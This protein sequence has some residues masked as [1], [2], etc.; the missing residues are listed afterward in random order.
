MAV[1]LA[2]SAAW[3]Q[4]VE[5]EVVAAVTLDP[6]LRAPAA[7]APLEAYVAQREAILAYSGD[8]ER[9][10]FGGDV[11]M[12][13]AAGVADFVVSRATAELEVFGAMTLH[14]ALCTQEDISMLLPTACSVL[15]SIVEEPNAGSGRARTDALVAAIRVDLERI[16][17]AIVRLVARRTSQLDDGVRLSLVVF[18]EIIDALRSGSDASQLTDRIFRRAL[19]C[20]VTG[21]GERVVRACASPGGRD[22]QR[23]LLLA[24]NLTVL[25][26]RSPLDAAKA[27]AFFGLDAASPHAAAVRELAAEVS[28]EA[29]LVSR[30]VRELADSE[31]TE[32]QRQE[33]SQALVRA[34]ATLVLDAEQAVRAATADALALPP[35]RT[36]T[37]LVDALFGTIRAAAEGE[38]TIGLAHIVQLLRAI[39]DFLAPHVREA[40][41]EGGLALPDEV[42]RPMTLVVALATAESPE[43]VRAILEQSAAPIGSWREKRRRPLVAISAFVGMAG[44]FDLLLTDPLRQ[45]F[46]VALHATVGLDLNFYGGLPGGTIGLYIHILD[47]GNL[48]SVPF[49]LDVRSAVVEDGMLVEEEVRAEPSFF[50]II[51]P[52]LY[53]RWG[54][55]DTPIVLAV[56]AS[57]VPQA[58]Q[59]QTSVNGADP[60]AV[61]ADAF[62]VSALLAVDTTLWVF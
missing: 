21:G 38:A 29:R 39:A 31:A 14:D 30:L 54:I 56:G 18:A 47:I 24:S 42:L 6:A 9:G 58:R 12:N 15:A 60:T 57:F 11:L 10:I 52:G 43:A 46:G 44:S 17:P 3:A 7:D 35:D 2:P 49:G 4:P 33:R 20:D 13:L 27:L 5:E 62:R 25:A 34:L 61:W 8:S 26:L 55:F 51:S 16:A 48:A 23:A 41:P 19:A 40:L 37:A 50:S 59:I 45:T 1:A 53:L 22:A 36:R 28:R 32:E